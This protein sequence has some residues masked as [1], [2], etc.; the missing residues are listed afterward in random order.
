MDR[1]RVLLVVQPPL[2][3]AP[4]YVHL[5]AEALV[6]RGHEV[7]I[8]CPPDSVLAVN[9][10]GGARIW[11]HAMTRSVSL[12]ADLRAAW[13]LRSLCR[14][15]G[16]EV[17]HC[18]SSKAGLFGLLASLM[19]G[20]RPLFSPHAPRSMAYPPSSPLR[21][22]ALTVER[23]IAGRSLGVIAVSPGEADYLIG[24]GITAPGKVRVVRTG[25]PLARASPRRR[26]RRLPVVAF[27]GRFSYQKDPALFVEVA[28]I[29]ARRGV[30]ARFLMLGDGEL[31]AAVRGAIA[32]H[33][34]GER[35]E[36][37]GWVPDARRALR[38]ASLLLVTSR[39]EAMPY[40]LLEAMAEGVPVVSARCEGL[41]DLL[42]RE[43]C[44]LMATTRDPAEAAS[45]VERVLTEAEARK[46]LVEGAWR[47]LL[48]FH[49]MEEFARA[50]EEA[51]RQAK[52]GAGAPRP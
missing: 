28:A 25:I 38:E 7:H 47:Y 42:D 43:G 30:A 40:V 52:A 34:L 10:P 37:R 22:V 15:L 9:P 4:R 20:S 50:L 51:Y 44:G 45:L 3:G 17:V 12:A 23:A 14:Q 8:A 41:G 39:Y 21:T 29:L 5:A 46:G 36:F 19:G 49:R 35:V 32:R 6:A 11:T 31:E 48:G 2:G 18:H 27:V 24:A 26:A 1:L 16:P 33:G 13:W